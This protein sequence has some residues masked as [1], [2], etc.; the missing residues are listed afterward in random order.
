MTAFLA[1]FVQGSLTGFVFLINATE[2]RFGFDDVLSMV[3][4]EHFTHWVCF[5]FESVCN[6]ASLKVAHSAQTCFHTSA[7]GAE[8][9]GLQGVETS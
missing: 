3:Y 1:Q 9:I 7:Q 4:V 6:Q 5:Q 8:G 2:K